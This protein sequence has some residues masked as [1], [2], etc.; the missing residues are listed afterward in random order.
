MKV[1]I[2]DYRGTPTTV[3]ITKEVANARILVLT[4]DE[5]LK[6]NYTDGTEDTFD[7]SD[8][9]GMD[10]YDDEYEVTLEDGKDFGMYDYGGENVKWQ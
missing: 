3:T 4:G 6:V 7:S 9:R 8:C 2:R 10:F 1:I 5:I